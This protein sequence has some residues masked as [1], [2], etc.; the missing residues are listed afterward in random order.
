MSTSTAH[1]IE[2][3]ILVCKAMISWAGPEELC[4][5][6]CKWNLY[7]PGHLPAQVQHKYMQPPHR[8]PHALFQPDAT[9]EDKAKRLLDEGRLIDALVT[10]LLHPPPPEAPLASPQT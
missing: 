7:P 8:Q 3:T 9:W 10:S 5:G 1:S 2:F 4:P 6:A